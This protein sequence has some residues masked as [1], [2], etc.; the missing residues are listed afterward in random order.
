MK[1]Y[2]HGHDERYAVE[3]M[4]ADPL[5]AGSGRC[6]RTVEPG[7]EDWC[8]P[9]A[10]GNR[11]SAELRRTCTARAALQPAEFAARPLRHGL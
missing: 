2:F 6:T 9:D 3:Q 8:S 4:P 1:L 7:E 10:C 5:P 11:R